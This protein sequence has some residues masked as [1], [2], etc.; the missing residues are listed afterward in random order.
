MLDTFDMDLIAELPE[1][2]LSS[3]G[4][5]AQE[6]LKDAPGLL[7]LSI[8]TIEGEPYLDLSR[9]TIDDPEVFFREFIEWMNHKGKF[10][11]GEYN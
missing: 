4:K 8:G 7:D 6:M 9:F 10:T 3:L 1:D 11:L 2:R 5:T